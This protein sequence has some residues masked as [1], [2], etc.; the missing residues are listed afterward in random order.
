MAQ[1][2]LLITNEE[3]PRAL[4]GISGGSADEKY[5][6]LSAESY[7]KI[8]QE[9][10]D[11]FHLKAVAITM[12]ESPSVLK[13]VWTAVALEGTTFHEDRRY[14]LE[15]VDRLGGGDSFSAGLLFGIA[16]QN[17]IAYGLKF[18]LAFSALKHTTPGDINWATRE[19]VEELMKGASARV[20]R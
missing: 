20:A 13:N 11:R 10:R 1:V 5:T 9:L 15:I 3:D 14:E 12:R 4:F 18:G 8:A 2:D 17:S 6:S 16:T 7:R 19:E